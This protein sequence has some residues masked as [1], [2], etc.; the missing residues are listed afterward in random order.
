[1][2]PEIDDGLSI[3]LEESRHP[4]VERLA[5]TG[6]AGRFVPNDI[7]IETSQPAINEIGIAPAA[8]VDGA[9]TELAISNGGEAGTTVDV[10]LY[11]LDGVSLY[12]EKIPIVPGGSIERRV[13]QAGPA[14]LVV[15]APKGAHV[16][17]GTTLRQQTGDVYGLASAALITPGLAGTARTSAVDPQVAQ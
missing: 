16:Y 5:P 7:A 8:V 11:N 17:G 1:M 2:R 12:T 4:V 14:Y 13:T 6:G 10:A 15:K 3:S 9:E